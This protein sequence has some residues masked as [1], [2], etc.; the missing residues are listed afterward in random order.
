MYVNLAT[1]LTWL[2]IAVMLF[3]LFRVLN[4]KREMP[5]GVVGKQWSNLTALVVLFAAGYVA[6]P[7]LDEL[8]KELLQLVVAGIFLF[9]AIYVLITINLIVAVVR[10][11]SE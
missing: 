7:F 3:A 2:S 1:A 10:V 6:I 4:L 11:L 9:G 5:G 8:S